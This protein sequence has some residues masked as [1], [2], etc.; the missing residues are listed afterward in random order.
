ME[1]VAYN[2]YIEEKTKFFAKHNYNCKVNVSRYGL[3]SYIVI[4]KYIFKDN[5]VWCEEEYYDKN[6]LIINYYSSEQKTKC[7][8]L[9]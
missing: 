2:R 8:I 7:V 1:I 3:E 9:D 5:V 4:I 6:V